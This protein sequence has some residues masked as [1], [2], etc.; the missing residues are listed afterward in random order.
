M[1]DCV[2]EGPE[3]IDLRDELEARI[4][5]EKGRNTRKCEVGADRVSDRRAEDR[6]K[7]EDRVVDVI[8]PLSGLANEQLHLLE[9]ALVATS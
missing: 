2:T 3:G 4:E 1:I 8:M 7:P 5:A 6:R 9:I